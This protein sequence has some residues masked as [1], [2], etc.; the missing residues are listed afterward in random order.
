[1]MIVIFFHIGQL[2]MIRRS[3]WVKPSRGSYNLWEPQFCLLQTPLLKT[4]HGLRAKLY[5]FSVLFLPIKKYQQ[6]VVEKMFAKAWKISVGSLQAI[7]G[8]SYFLNVEA[9][10]RG[11]P[12]KWPL[13]D[14]WEAA[15]SVAFC[16]LQG[17]SELLTR[18]PMER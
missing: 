11:V 3:S 13:T 15:H 16:R 14:S 6:L 7:A 4:L 18:T 1:M 12:G 2:G 8:Q 10:A 5:S 9:G 17:N